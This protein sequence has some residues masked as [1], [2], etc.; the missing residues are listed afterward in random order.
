MARSECMDDGIRIGRQI[1][2]DG[3][4]RR[5]WDDALRAFG[6]RWN[7]TLL[8]KIVE[9]SFDMSVKSGG[10]CHIADD[11]GCIRHIRAPCAGFPLM[12]I[13]LHLM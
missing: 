4:G 6:T 13:S 11:V 2:E 12:Y 3:L 9:C 7:S 1:W 10:V 8:R 5:I